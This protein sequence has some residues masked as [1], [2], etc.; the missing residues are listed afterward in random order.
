MNFV[1]GILSACAGSNR[2]KVSTPD[3]VAGDVAI[4]PADASANVVWWSDGTVDENGIQADTWLLFGDASDYE[5]MVTGTGD[6]PGGTGN[7]DV[8]QAMDSDLGYALSQTTEGN[9]SFS[10]TYQIREIGRAHV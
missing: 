8:W 2:E 4:D 1:A 6:E 3:L 5:L 9:K 7:L 10:G